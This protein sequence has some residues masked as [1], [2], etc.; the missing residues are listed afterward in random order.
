MRLLGETA[1]CACAKVELVGSPHGFHSDGE[2]SERTFVRVFP[3][4]YRLV[5]RTGDSETDAGDVDLAP[6]AEAA[7]E[8]AVR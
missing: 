3:G 7:C 4:R 1:V 8:V 5:L 2:G 6:G